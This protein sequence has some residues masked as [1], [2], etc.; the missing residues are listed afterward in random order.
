MSVH[1]VTAGEWSAC[2]AAGAC[3]PKP[4][5]DQNLPILRV[6]WREA[7]A[8]AKWLSE[9]TGQSYRLPTESEWEYAARGGTAGAWWWGERFE[10]NRL[11]RG[12]VKPVGSFEAN[13]FG[14]HDMLSNAREWV[15]DCYVN[16]FTQTPTDGSAATGGDCSMRVIRGGAWSSP[17]A[18][19]RVAN[20]SRIAVDG[21]PLYMGFR[22]AADIG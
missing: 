22:L 20:R 16:N 6:S 15:A 1:E 11:A 3:A 4:A 5:A 19:T 8:Y 2:A 17:P 14:L 7:N 10:P 13:P 9:K 12:E 21:K 18:D